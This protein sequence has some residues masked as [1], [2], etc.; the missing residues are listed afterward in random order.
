MAGA[1]PIKVDEAAARAQFEEALRTH[2]QGFETFFL[3]R[4]LGLSFAYLPHDA[5]DTEK[6]ICRLNF[7]VTD[8]LLNPQ[9][10]LQGG[11]VA[12]ALDISMGH[13]VNKVAGAGATIELKVQYLRPAPKGQVTVEGSFIRKGRAISFMQSKMWAE[14]G[15]LTAHATA[16]FKMPD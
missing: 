6:E 10:V 14:S 12:T 7:E 1:A 4:Y 8:R 3:A 9:S 5:P 2:E 11:I 16:T 13:L 15:K